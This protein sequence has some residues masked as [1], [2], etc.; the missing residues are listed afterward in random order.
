[1]DVAVWIVGALLVLGAL[2]LVV[3]LALP[4]DHVA[5]RT[6]S[7]SADPQAL[8]DAV[9]DPAL[10]RASAG[11]L[12]TEEVESVP[13]KLLVTKIVGEKAFGGTWT[14]EVGPADRGSTLTI[15]ERGEVYNPLFRFVSR[16]VLGHHRTIDG[17]M[18]RLRKRF[19]A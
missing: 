11:D 18:S 13:P 5:I 15:T 6:R 19:P 7:F 12:A 9:H 2:V 4:V 8:W 1:M 10:A 16:F 3:G 14:F 17:Y